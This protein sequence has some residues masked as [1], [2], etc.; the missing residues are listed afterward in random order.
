MTIGTHG[1]TTRFISLTVFGYAAAVIAVA[2]AV[3]W[4]SRPIL[5]DMTRDAMQ[6]AAVFKA[7]AI[8]ALV[9]ERVNDSQILARDDAIEQLVVGYA[10]G[11]ARA[12]DALV[13]FLF[14]TSARSAAFFDFTGTELLARSED[15]AVAP[16]LAPEI[17]ALLGPL[18]SDEGDRD[19]A[20]LFL[21]L[22]GDLADARLIVATPV[23]LSG[24]TEGA[25]VA[26]YPINL[27]GILMENT[28]ID[29]PV[30]VLT[31]GAPQVLAPNRSS[32]SAAWAPVGDTGLFAVISNQSQADVLGVR[33]VNAVMGASVAVLAVPFLA[34][35]VLGGRILVEPQRRLAQSQA[36]FQ[37]QHEDLSK[38]ATIIQNSNDAI[39]TTDRDGRVL[40]GNPAFF[41]V[42]GYSQDEM[43]GQKPQWLL[44][45]PGENGEANAKIRKAL[46]ELRYVRT[47]LKNYTR[48]G[49]E[50][51]I[52]L[53]ITPIFNSAG[54]FLC[55]AGVSADITKQKRS[56]EALRIARTETEH[57]ALHDAMTGLANRRYVDQVMAGLAEEEA[58]ERCLVRID[59]DHFKAVNDTLGHAAGDHVLRVVANLM[60]DNC[61]STDF[62]ARVGGDEFL[63]LMGRNRTEADA[64]R[65]ALTLRE[66]I[67]RDMQFEGSIV[68]V[69][70]SFGIASI[71]P[72]LVAPGDLLVSADAA[73]YTSKDAGRNTITLYTPELH[74]NVMANRRLSKEVEEALEAGGFEPW[75][76]PQFDAVTGALVGVEA[77]AR[78]RHP[79][80]GILQPNAFLPIVEKLSM[81]R[82]LDTIIYRKG[83]QDIADFH[84]AGIHIP[85]VSFNVSAMQIEN[86]NLAAIVD[87]VDIADTVVALEILESVLLEDLAEEKLDNLFAL[88]DRGFRL[89][90]DD[91]GSGHASIAGL[92]KLRPE[93]IKI[94]QVLV[95]PVV[96]SLVA[97]ELI[98]SIVDIGH[99]L[100]VSVTAEGV[101]TL[102]HAQILRDCGCNTLQG[103]YFSRP[104]LG[105]SLAA[106]LQTTGFPGVAEADPP[107]M[108]RRA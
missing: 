34:I 40:W 103:Y 76:Q 105:S 97:Q 94:D 14:E 36:E 31:R 102:A 69:G 65:L 59:L 82:E 108:S 27:A 17:A 99:T 43:L 51:W 75:Y 92:L 4:M 16:R 78:W 18:L 63:I 84:S 44:Q 19:A 15:S 42:T 64:D 106:R 56:E 22:T 8:V 10:A 48:D 96:H 73:L 24:F 23:M 52:S 90:L 13:A 61:A 100:D 46:A 3:W 28:S 35:L 67:G 53:S 20:A 29:G 77:L 26:E 41:A 1:F 30:Y 32:A 66:E 7:Q 79:E 88:R 50:Y 95:R 89:E 93:V 49:Q 91:F 58:P 6:D 74:A 98:S 62:P 87:E 71:K 104:I 86:L 85:K 12:R 57:R 54:Q 60:R 5:E 2:W 21:V 81:T 25:V 9:D 68:R 72:G 55:F 80:L 39:L 47:E 101:E 70:A 11:T 107:D 37:R 33:L 83:L 38:L 45:K